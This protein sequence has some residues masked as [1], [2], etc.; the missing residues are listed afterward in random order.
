MVPTPQLFSTFHMNSA[1][2]MMKSRV[3]GSAACARFTDPNV[4]KL[5]ALAVKVD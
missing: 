2:A 5:P 1:R 4:A 3:F